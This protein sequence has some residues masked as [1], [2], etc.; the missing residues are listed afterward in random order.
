M[1]SNFPRAV[2]LVLAHEGGYVD[3]PKDPGGAT[4][5]GVTLGTY[6]RYIKR[7]G[8]KD[9]LRRL[10]V[11]EASQC[12]RKH[13]WDKVRG[14]DLPSGVDYAVFDYA[15]N[16]GPGRAAKALQS[17]VGAKLDGAIGPETIGKAAAYNPS[18]VVNRLCDERLAFLKRLNTWSTFGKG[19]SSRV[20]GVRE[21]ALHMIAFSKPQA[22]VPP[23]KP[24]TP[25]A[26]E[27]PASAPRRGGWIAVVVLAIGGAITGLVNGGWNW[28]VSL[29]T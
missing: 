6:R 8:T 9:D 14:D 19:W 4:N 25:P 21:D 2:K 26:P 11:E 20:A 5:L 17:V 28:L 10:T 16:S 7:H 27:T 3:H 1:N 24:V 13:Y 18:V 22:P 15:V 23:P 29:F 12:Y